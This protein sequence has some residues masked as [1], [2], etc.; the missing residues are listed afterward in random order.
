MIMRLMFEQLA[1]DA[2]YFLDW[3][4]LAADRNVAASAAI[5]LGGATLM[6]RCSTNSSGILEVRRS[7][8]SQP[9]RDIPAVG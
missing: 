6:K 9:T 3:L 5:V 7:R 2:R 4:H 1:T 8:Q